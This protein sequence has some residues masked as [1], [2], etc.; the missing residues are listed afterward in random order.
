[1]TSRAPLPPA[2]D[3]APFTTSEALQKGVS[4]SRLRALDLDSRFHGIRIT[5]AE[6]HSLYQ[7]CVA[8]SLRFPSDAFISGETA[9]VL[10]QVPLPRELE[11]SN[12]IHVTV[13]EGRRALSGRG[14]RGHAA[15]VAPTDVVEWKGL[16]LS[17][18]ARMWCELGASL[19]LPDLVAAG[20]YLV[21]RELA[22][23]SVTQ[24]E[25]SL[26]VFAG[27]Q[28][29]SRLAHALGMLDDNSAS[30]RESHLRVLA[31]EQGLTGY[32]TNMKI[33]T[34]GGFTYY[35]DLTFPTERVVVEYQSRYHFDLDQQRKDM[36]RR[37]RLEAD[38][39]AVVFINADDLGNPRELA[40]R[41][42]AVLSSHSRHFAGD[43][44]R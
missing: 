20:D 33:V 9:A 22:H 6:P 7:L 21:N 13:P 23:T 17:S 29:R 26:A 35:G 36:T 16:A 39:W 15:R 19:A 24:L 10:R 8:R 4:S 27:R 14:L 1:M 43:A 11:Q 34:S 40:A 32:V 31:I 30:R 44:R 2:L 12:I 18:A 5:A 3:P 37:S 25:A 38:G 42:R 41:I 28:G